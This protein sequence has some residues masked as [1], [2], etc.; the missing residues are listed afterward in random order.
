MPQQKLDFNLMLVTFSRSFIF[1]V[2][3]E[4]KSHFRNISRI[5]D[6]VGCDKCK[7]WGKLQV[8]HYHQVLV[9]LE[10]LYYYI[11]Y[12]YVSPDTGNRNCIED[13][14]FGTQDHFSR[15]NGDSYTLQCSRK[16]GLV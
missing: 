12:V 14:F 6:C 1:S 5:M 4:F 15:Q 11:I 10:P 7:L 3:N 2:Q 8:I 9:L 16:V 13:T